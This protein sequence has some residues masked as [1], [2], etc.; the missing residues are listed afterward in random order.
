LL[1]LYHHDRLD[2]LLGGGESFLTHAPDPRRELGRSTLMDDCRS[3]EAVP[4]THEGIHD[5]HLDE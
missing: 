5:V 3:L 4:L 1:H 2:P